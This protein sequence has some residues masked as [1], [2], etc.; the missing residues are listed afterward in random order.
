[1]FHCYYFCT[2]TGCGVPSFLL[3]K[4]ILI[5][6]IVMYWKS[7]TQVF[8]KHVYRLLLRIL[9]SHRGYPIVR[10]LGWVLNIFGIFFVMAGHEHYS[11]DVFIAFYLTTR[12]AFS[13]PILLYFH[14][15]PTL[16]ALFT[17]ACCCYKLNFQPSNHSQ[18]TK[19]NNYN[20]NDVAV[21]V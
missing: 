5:L 6:A 17:A 14:I 4:V 15:L 12:W 18:A 8:T 19:W 20:A 13:T 1:M 9:D 7:V 11:I 2:P 3:F 10:T 21:C 16:H